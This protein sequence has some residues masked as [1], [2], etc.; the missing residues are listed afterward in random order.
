L[1]KNTGWPE[2]FILW[3]LPLSR[4]LNYQHAILRAEGL[5]TVAPSTPTG[6]AEFTT[7]HL[8]TFFADPGEEPDLTQ[9]ELL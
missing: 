9:G 7:T 4:A 3:Q 8:A 6:N 5:W 1:A 2:A